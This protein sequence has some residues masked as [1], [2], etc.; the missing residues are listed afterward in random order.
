MKLRWASWSLLCS[1]FALTG[2]GSAPP[3]SIAEIKT[4]TPVE[5]AYFSAW[6]TVA[7]RANGHLT[8]VYSGG[9]EKHVCPFGRV[10][11]MESRDQGKSWSWPRVLFDSNIDDRDAGVIETKRG[12]LLVSTFSALNHLSPSS[13]GFDGDLTQE[14]EARWNR[15]EAGMHEEHRGLPGAYLL[16]SEDGGILWQSQ[17]VPVSSPHGPIQLEDGRLL[18][19]GIRGNNQIFAL[20]PIEREMGVWESTDDGMTWRH[21]SAIPVRGT[22]DFKDYHELHGVEAADG[23]LVVHIRSHAGTS[24]D[25]RQKR[26]TLQTISRDGGRTWSVPESIE[27]HGYPSHLMSLQDGRLL[28]SYS[29]RLPGNYSI[30]ARVSDT[31]GMHW[32]EPVELW[33]TEQRVDLGYPSTVQLVDG[34]LLTIWYEAPASGAKAVLRQAKWRLGNPKGES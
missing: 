13:R 24:A 19:P 6:P 15:H 18:F 29:V 17:R 1:S 12:T 23:T 33:R 11:S 14:Q 34:S 9:R 30:H 31:H 8:V 22:D 10:E 27:V 4:I 26:E 21:L 16:R 32:S 25:A 28:M 5:Y 7:L 20:N 2:L 3:H